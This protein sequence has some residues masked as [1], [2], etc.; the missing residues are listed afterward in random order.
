MQSQVLKKEETTAC[1]SG[2][3]YTAEDQAYQHKTKVTPNS[4][5][6]QNPHRLIT[7]QSQLAQTIWIVSCEKE[8]TQQVSIQRRVPKQFVHS[9]PSASNLPPC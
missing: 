2:L 5:N 9:D 7:K 4:S 8:I 1:S 3:L 6:Q